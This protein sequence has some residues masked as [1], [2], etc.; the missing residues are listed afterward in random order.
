MCVMC[1]IEKLRT[2]FGLADLDFRVLIKIIVP[3]PSHIGNGRNAAPFSM[4][5]AWPFQEAPLR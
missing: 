2:R 5:G 3:V 1:N 4:A